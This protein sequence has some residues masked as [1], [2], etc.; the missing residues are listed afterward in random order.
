[1]LFISALIITTKEWGK[2]QNFSNKDQL[3][4]Q[5]ITDTV[6]FYVACKKERGIPYIQIQQD[7][8]KIFS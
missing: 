1:M 5:W 8:Q 3:I 7:L 4:K 6:T 2:S